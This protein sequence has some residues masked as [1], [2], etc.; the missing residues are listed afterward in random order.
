MGMPLRARTA[1]AAAAASFDCV[2]VFAS[3][4]RTVMTW[5]GYA[6]APV[7]VVGG[8]AAVDEALAVCAATAVAATVDALVG[9]AAA[10]PVYAAAAAAGTPLRVRNESACASAGGGEEA[11]GA[12]PGCVGLAAV[13]RFALFHLDRDGMNADGT[14]GLPAGSV[15]RPYGDTVTGYAPVNG[16]AVGL[17]AVT[18]WAPLTVAMPGAVGTYVVQTALAPHTGAAMPLVVPANRLRAYTLPP[19]YAS[20]NAY[21]RNFMCRGPATAD[22]DGVCM[23]AATVVA[24]D[25]AVEAAAAAAV[26]S[27]DA[28]TQDVA[29]LPAHRSAGGGGSLADYLV[30][31]FALKAAAWDTVVA[32]WREKVR[33]DAPRPASVVPTVMRTDAAGAAWTPPAG[34][35]SAVQDYP[36]ASAAVC[37]GV[38]TIVGAIGG[39]P[40]P[41][42][43]TCGDSGVWDGLHFPGAVAAGRALGEAVA[44]DVLVVLGCRAPGT[45]GLP[46]CPS[47]APQAED[48]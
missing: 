41:T 15:A 21:G 12:D 1:A 9:E 13:A 23:A 11:A 22:P 44:G 42:A 7:P 2:G 27:R 29:F 16:P 43:A 48:M 5:D 18:R 33:H 36:S 35:T 28:A 25:S 14:D 10:K 26:R 45:P 46:D 4:G 32:A 31:E 6:S 8:P 38:S 39:A 24:A 3:S 40:D 37:A 17:R 20:P 19:P 34:E 47:E 30:A